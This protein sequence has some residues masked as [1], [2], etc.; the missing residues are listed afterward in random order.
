[1]TFDADGGSGTMASETETV[2]TTAALAPNSFTCS[3]YSFTGWNTAPDGSGTSYADVSPYMFAVSI[4]LYAQWTIAAYT[5]TFDA[6]GG[7]GTMASE[8]EHY[9]VATALTMNTFTHTGYTFDGWNTAASGGGTG[10]AHGA[11][12]SFTASV[13]LY[14]Q[15][16]INAYTVTFDA[17]G[18]SGTMA[19]ETETVG[20]TAALAPNSFT[21]SG[22]SFTGW[23]TAPDGSG[24][25]YADGSPYMFAV[26]IT[27][28]AQWTIAAPAGT[29]PGL[30]SSNW[31]GYILTGQTGGYQSVSAEWTVPTINCTSIP[32][33][34]TSEWVGVNGSTG[35]PGLFQDGTSSYCAGG[36]QVN[37]G[38]WT[39]QAESY[40]GQNLFRVVSGDL[41]QAKVFQAASGQW[42]YYI[43][44]LTSGAV[45]TAVEAY[46]GQGLSAEWIAEDPGNPSSGG[47]YPLGDWCFSHS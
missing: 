31:S 33:G 24:T 11:T 28:Y 35:A 17:N 22:Y 47:L 3:G 41:I 9:N 37:H 38:W 44:D 18:G 23:N 32:D 42:I 45:S 2:G 5:V 4:T 13:T 1:V 29:F 20:T 21:Y 6:N 15:W 10:Y 40:L 43:K 8:T 14:A 34:F 16:T 19:S 30:Y 25:S 26:S 39:D 12:Y 27:L 7:S 36:Q 46:S